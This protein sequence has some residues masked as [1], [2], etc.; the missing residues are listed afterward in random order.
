MILYNSE[1]LLYILMAEL[2]DKYVHDLTKL[3]D[4]SAMSFCTL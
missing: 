4:E 2:H 1:I 3:T